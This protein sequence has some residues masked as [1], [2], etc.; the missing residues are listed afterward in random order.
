MCFTI[1]HS[2]DK[3]EVRNVD[4]GVALLALGALVVVEDVVDLD[5]GIHGKYSRLTYPA[6]VGYHGSQLPSYIAV[7]KILSIGDCRAGSMRFE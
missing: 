1:E 2:I 3:R 7:I 5:V 4:L 6:S